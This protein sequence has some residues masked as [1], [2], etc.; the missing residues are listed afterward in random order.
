MNAE[1]N[2]NQPPLT[3][4]QQ[5][6]DIAIAVLLV[7]IGAFAVY[8]YQTEAAEAAEAAEEKSAGTSV[9]VSG[10]VQDRWLDSPH[11][12]TF[13]VA[14]DGTN[15]ECVVCHA[16]TEFLPSM[17]DIPP[18][19]YSA[20][21]CHFEVEEMPELTIEAEWQSIQCKTCHAV[22]R[23]GTIQ[24]EYA[25]LEVAAIDQYAD[26]AST[27]ELCEK[28]H[29]DYAAPGHAAITLGG[30]HEDNVCTDC[31]EAH[32]PTVSCS[33][34][35]CHESADTFEGHDD[36]HPNV[37]CVACH[38]AG[39]MEVGP[40]DGDDNTWTTFTTITVDEEANTFPHPSHH[41]Q[42]EVNCDRC[43]FSDNPW[44]LSVTD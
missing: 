12:S 33:T 18:S 29:T 30:V 1:K 11:A 14:D 32:N 41:I 9:I 36:D 16:P 5:I 42:Q 40:V 27:T 7:L 31:H 8:H 39:E 4:F 3:Q 24:P 19:C 17:D 25:W 37:A 15:A 13:V 21:G 20:P 35:G 38:D 44:N 23:D 6:R 22:D 28:C 2:N 43:H 10:P 34:G 26:V